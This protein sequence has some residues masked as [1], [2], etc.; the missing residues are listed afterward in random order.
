MITRNSQTLSSGDY[1]VIQFGFPLRMNGQHVDSCRYPINGNIYGDAY[2]H[3]NLWIIVCKIDANSIGVPSGGS[4]TRNLQINNF[5]TPWY[6]LS[7]SE[8]AVTVYGYSYN[9][10]YTTKGVLS[11]LYPNEGWKQSPNTPTLTLTPIHQTTPYRG[12][13]DD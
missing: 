3:E 2:Y 5:Y 1:Y 9:N 10:K 8:R 6:L 7:T 12:S 11:D 4:T 13:R